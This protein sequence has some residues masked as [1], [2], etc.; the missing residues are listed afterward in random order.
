MPISSRQSLPSGSLPPNHTSGRL[1]QPMEGHPIAHPIGSH[2]MISTCNPESMTVDERRQE[3]AAILAGGVLR[4]LR[5]A[6]SAQSPPPETSSEACENRLDVPSKGG[7][8]G[9][10]PR[11]HVST[12]QSLSVSAEAMGS[13]Y[14]EVGR[15]RFARLGDGWAC[16]FR[17]TVFGWVD[18][19][20]TQVSRHGGCAWCE[21]G[22]RP[23]FGHGRRP[24]DRRTRARRC[25]RP[26]RT[27]G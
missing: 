9:S 1:G 12:R 6:R 25:A 13:G 21:T 19:V 27:D 7:S 17:W 10:E 22:V 15:A 4:Y 11:L 8:R 23:G 20:N 26:C 3:I 14:E 2:A 5:A 24:R 16:R 18:R